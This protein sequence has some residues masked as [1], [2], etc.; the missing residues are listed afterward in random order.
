[1]TRLEFLSVIQYLNPESVFIN[2][3]VTTLYKRTKSCWCF[4]LLPLKCM[5]GV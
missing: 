4:I 2:H 3:I 5:N 1:M